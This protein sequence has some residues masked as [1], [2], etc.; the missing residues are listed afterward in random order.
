M[1]NTTKNQEELKKSK[2]LRLKKKQMLKLKKEADAA[3]KLEAKV[4]SVIIKNTQGKEMSVD[5]YFFKGVLPS[6]FEGT[7][8]KSQLKEKIYWT[9]SIKVFNSRTS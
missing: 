7:L 9:F 5:D 8:W 3:K 4:K 1:E 2:T 6:G